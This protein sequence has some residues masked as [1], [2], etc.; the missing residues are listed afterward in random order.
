[1]NN[2]YSSKSS[3]SSSAAAA[4][5]LR[6]RRFGSASPG[7]IPT[8][9]ND[10]WTQSS[11]TTSIKQKELHPSKSFSTVQRRQVRSVTSTPPVSCKSRNLPQKTN[12][13]TDYSLQTVNAPP[14]KQV[15]MLKE[16]LAKLQSEL[17]V[18]RGQVA[19]LELDNQ[20]TPTKTPPSKTQS[21]Q[22]ILNTTSP[23]SRRKKS[24]SISRNRASRK[25]S[26]SANSEPTDGLSIRFISGPGINSS[27]QSHTT[28][29][30][31]DLTL[32][33][34]DSGYI[35]DAAGLW[36]P[37]NGTPTNSATQSPPRNSPIHKSYSPGSVEP[38]RGFSRI[39]ISAVALGRVLAG[40]PHVPDHQLNHHSDIVEEQEPVEEDSSRIPPT[41]EYSSSLSLSSPPIED[42]NGISSSEPTGGQPPAVSRQ[43]RGN[44]F[45]S[46]GGGRDRGAMIHQHASGDRTTNGGNTGKVITTLQSDLLY[47]RTALDQSKSQLRLSQRAVE[48]LNR[49][50][51][52]LKESMSRLRLENEGLSK[53][54]SRK[55]RTVSELMERLKRSEGELSTLKQEK[56]ELDVNFKKIS[57]ETDEIV[58]D[59]VRRRDRAETQYE[60]VR[61]G[62]KSLSE[63]WK[64]D[65]KME[66]S[67]LKYNT[68]AKLHASRSGALSRIETDLNSLQNSKEGFIAKYTSELSLL[69]AHLSEEEKKSSEGL[70]LVKEVSEEC[71]RFKRLL[72]SHSDSSSRAPQA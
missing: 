29:I 63:G 9:S 54:L 58:K 69:K 38:S 35:K 14:N 10:Y 51:E 27:R 4:A 57:K 44:P 39:P 67:R 1:M 49:Q 71:A 32:P 23:N 68:L 19:K 2:N 56:K 47:A 21:S 36:V 41:S 13:T 30:M 7:L 65:V 53:M 62:V 37:I 61:S 50:T 16:Q 52:D 31:D 46:S 64:R 12:K 40:D 59:S 55:E 3:S 33:I 28:P 66:D 43:P 42:P 20:L 22:Q 11:K 6:V 26:S 45:F 60:A 72:R 24:L 70:E 25:S 34:S 48:S 17:R 5:A 15:T 8:D 18:A